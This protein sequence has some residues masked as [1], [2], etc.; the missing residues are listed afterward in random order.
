MSLDH[1]KL[2]K[3][4]DFGDGKIA[5]CPACAE[6]GQDRKGEHLRI[7]SD[8]KFGCCVHPGDSE[9]RKRIYAL[10]GLRGHRG[11]SL[12][13]ATK[14][15]IKVQG[16]ILGRLGRVFETTAPTVSSSDASDG[17]S[18]VQSTAEETRTLRTAV[19]ESNED[20]MDLFR[21]SRTPPSLLT[22]IEKENVHTDAYVYKEFGEGVRSVREEKGAV[23][24]VQTTEKRGRLPFLTADGSLS[25]PFDSPER[26]HWWKDGGQS[27]EETLKEVKERS[28]CRDEY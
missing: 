27:V 8:G 26:Y 28:E 18:E 15:T 14:S 25:I 11:I 10:A 13:V 16:G 7:Y 6:G 24:G 3:L 9:H 12:K 21:T 1:S 17:V 22:R 4:R 20:S 2:E 19:S 23:V 5:R